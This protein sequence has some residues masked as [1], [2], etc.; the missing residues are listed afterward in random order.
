M[1]PTTF[2]HEGV[3]DFALACQYARTEE[4]KR[5]IIG[6]RY[7]YYL[8]LA[9]KLFADYHIGEAI[10]YYHWI[11]EVKEL[12]SQNNSLWEFAI[13]IYNRKITPEKF[14]E[15]CDSDNNFL[16]PTCG[17]YALSRKN[18]S[19]ANEVF[20]KLTPDKSASFS[21]EVFLAQWK[22]ISNEEKESTLN[23][24]KDF[25]NGLQP[26]KDVLSKLN[27]SRAHIQILEFEEICK[28]LEAEIKKLHKK[29]AEKINKEEFKWAHDI[30]H[31]S[32]P[33]EEVSEFIS[34]CAKMI[35]EGI[36]TFQIRQT[37][38]EPI[39]LEKELWFIHF[40]KISKNHEFEWTPAKKRFVSYKAI[41]LKK[42]KP[43]YNNIEACK[44]FLTN[45]SN[46]IQKLDK[47][48]KYY[49]EGLKVKLSYKYLKSELL[50]LE[51]ISNLL[52]D[53][54]F[55][56]EI[57]KYEILSSKKVFISYS[58]K[59]RKPM[60]ELKNELEALNIKVTVDE[61]HIFPSEEIKK[62]TDEMVRK[63]DFTLSLVSPNSLV[64]PWV[65]QESIAAFKTEWYK[66]D[67]GG[68]FIPIVLSEKV[69]D[70]QLRIEV[71][72]ELEKKR[73]II[74]KEIRARGKSKKKD[75]NE[76]IDQIDDLL[77]ELGEIFHRIDNTL[78]I[79]FTTPNN[80]TGSFNDLINVMVK[81]SLERRP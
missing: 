44:S 61:N 19:V 51:K 50:F 53:E 2:L 76:K 12:D 77:N 64:S 65:G 81:K 34:R 29:V 40:L 20:K 58:T 47:G 43:F 13:N 60:L 52:Y 56:Q 9:R 8:D 79:D 69:R 63:N 18:I 48:F 22:I 6:R 17:I 67:L 36:K 38:D 55:Q 57:K 62:R 28:K 15:S 23:C 54:K 42:G 16:L 75:L 31:H 25:V 41:D 4:D 7:E 33:E 14:Y 45:F 66:S 21:K 70:S 10:Y 26:A 27:Y 37:E 59:D 73:E 78:Y 11:N 32:P 71:R 80:I 1:E 3:R 24:F 30:F 5:A 72:K 39:R 49:I 46:K 35:E 74:N 68:R